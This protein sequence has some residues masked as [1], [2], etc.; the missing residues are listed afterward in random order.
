MP[1]YAGYVFNCRT[2]WLINEA[3]STASFKQAKTFP[4]YA[5]AVRAIMFFTD[6]WDYPIIIIPEYHCN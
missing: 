2:Y 3:H 4:S 1:F 6:D 5:D